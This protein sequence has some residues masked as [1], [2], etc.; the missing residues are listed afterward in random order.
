MV[1]FNLH[2]QMGRGIPFL[3]VLSPE[4]VSTLTY[5]TFSVGVANS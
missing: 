2:L 5:E 1:P 4:E 3:S